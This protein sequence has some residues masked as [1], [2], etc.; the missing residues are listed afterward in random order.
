MIMETKKYGNSETLTIDL[1][2]IPEEAW[3]SAEALEAEFREITAELENVGE[4]DADAPF[5]EP[6]PPPA[7]GEAFQE[8]R[9]Y[10]RYLVNWKVAVVNE[11]A[12]KDHIFHGRARDISL[13]GL[14]LLS[15]HNL[16]ISNAVEVLIAVPS[17]SPGHPAHVVEVR[18]TLAYAVLEN[19]GNFRI[20]V[21]FLEFKRDGRL[22]LEKRLS[23]RQAVFC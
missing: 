15:D 8:K 4:F 12:G 1:E 17:H 2:E 20:G 16:N 22:L 10:R 23:E 7:A 11:K 21:T 18:S 6:E 5:C 3:I 19:G 13:G 9:E 14:C